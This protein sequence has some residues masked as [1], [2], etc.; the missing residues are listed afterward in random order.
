MNINWK[1]VRQKAVDIAI[2]TS[3]NYVKQIEINTRNIEKTAE[4]K[5]KQKGLSLSD[6][7]YDKLDDMYDSIDNVY[8]TIYGLEERYHSRFKKMNEDFYEEDDYYDESD[9]LTNDVVQN[10]E[11]G[12]CQNRLTKIEIE[13]KAHAQ[14]NSSSKTYELYQDDILKLDK[15]WEPLGKLKNVDCEL[16]S[17]DIAGVLRL[18]IKG[19]TVYIVRVIEIKS[20]GFSKKISDLKSITSISN[21]KLREMIYKNIDYI[22]VEIL[23]IGKKSEDVDFVRSLEK[24]MIKYYKPNF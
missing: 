13:A 5:A 18:R 9:Y 15:M 12:E 7:A 2:D 4:R 1:K 14:I 21:L 8:D 11:N 16:V 24:N 22:E 3:K 19:Q 10:D 23:S 6:E 17:T 20:G